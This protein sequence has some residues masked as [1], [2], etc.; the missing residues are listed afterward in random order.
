MCKITPKV[1]QNGGH[2]EFKD[3]GCIYNILI[4]TI[5]FAE[6]KNMGVAT[7]IMTLSRSRAEIM[8]IMIFSWRPF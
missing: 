2:L 4:H 5:A 3:N 8:A 1:G 7:K 6:I